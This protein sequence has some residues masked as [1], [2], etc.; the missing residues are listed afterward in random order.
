MA[1]DGTGGGCHFPSISVSVSN[2]KSLR[3]H[4]RT[5]RR[6]L[7]AA[8]QRAHG[9]GLARLLGRSRLF[10]NAR[11]LALYLPADG[12]IDT[13]P[14]LTLAR[15]RKRRCF[16]PVL[17][18]ASHDALWF[19][20]H[21]PGDPLRPNRFGI[22]E[23]FPRRRKV[24]PAW[25]LDLILMPLVGFDEEG[26]RLGMGGGFY[27]RTLAFLR[28]RRHWRRPRLVGLA[29]GCQGVARLPINPWDVPLDGVAT[30]AR[31][32]LWRRG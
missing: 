2:L 6:A 11:S 14:L 8:E 28:H 23:P 5:L 24:L 17:R 15:R 19:V 3:R 10:R 21:R 4:L 30:E 9:K 26:N 13:A 18:G 29:H 7:S 22:P 1:G 16:L 32:Y 31:L 27:D 12:E 25:G 20:E